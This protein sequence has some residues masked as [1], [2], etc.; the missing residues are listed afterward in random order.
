M[1]CRNRVLTIFAV[2]VAGGTA[3]VF[4]ADSASDYSFDCDV[5][6]ENILYKGS[7]GSIIDLTED[8]IQN[9][10]IINNSTPDKSFDFQSRY[11]LYHEDDKFAVDG[12]IAIEKVIFYNGWTFNSISC[13]RRFPSLAYFSMKAASF[14]CKDR[15][16]NNT[17]V[18][19]WTTAKGV[20]SFK[21]LYADQVVVNY[22]LSSRRGMAAPCETRKLR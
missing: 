14:R 20:E 22:E 4:Y 18:F 17:H 15:M 10:I 3:S 19:N 6:E 12:M 1:R 5:K 13:N 9:I 16:T 7:D 2:T 21:T 11:K 8:R